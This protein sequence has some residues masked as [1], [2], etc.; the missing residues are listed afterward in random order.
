MSQQ[1]RCCHGNATRTT[2]VAGESYVP[3]QTSAAV[4]L[5]VL[6]DHAQFITFNRNQCKVSTSV[7]RLIVFQ[8][9]TNT[10]SVLNQFRLHQKSLFLCCFR[11]LSFFILFY[12]DDAV[13]YIL[14]RGF[15]ISHCV[16]VFI[17]ICCCRNLNSYL[18]LTLQMSVTVALLF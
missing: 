6:F 3:S 16:R 10:S 2:S 11:F 17:N 9:L 5:L 14:A 15:S 7:S 18:S 1:E 13:I 4:V 8:T 12:A